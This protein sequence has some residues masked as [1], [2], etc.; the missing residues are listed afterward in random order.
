MVAGRWCDLTTGLVLASQVERG[1]RLV[2]RGGGEGGRGG[3]E[4][5]RRSHVRV[6]VVVE[7]HLDEC[8]LPMDLQVLS[9]RRR[10]GVGLV[11]PAHP[12][13]EGLLRGVDVHVLL[14]VA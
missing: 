7:A 10:V 8:V 1:H 4:R 5:R 12:A 6:G 3:V 14:A 11:A 13:R 9:Q 2:V